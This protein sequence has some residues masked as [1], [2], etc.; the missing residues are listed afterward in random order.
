M[1]PKKRLPLRRFPP[2]PTV[3]RFL[4]FYVSDCAPSGD[5]SAIHMIPAVNTVTAEANATA[6]GCQDRL[7]TTGTANTMLPRWYLDE[8]PVRIELPFEFRAGEADSRG[9]TE[10]AERRQGF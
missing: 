8:T 9:K 7:R 10:A 1:L 4:R 5:F 6:S 3:L 2:L